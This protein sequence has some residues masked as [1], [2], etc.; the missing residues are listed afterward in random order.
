MI[1]IAHVFPKLE[2]VK[3]LVI[4]LSKKRRFRKHF[5]SEHLKLSK[6]LEKSPL[7]EF[8]Y[9]FHHSGEG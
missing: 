3:I 1:V 5:D 2:T 7:E 8:P 6:I 9:V 4:K